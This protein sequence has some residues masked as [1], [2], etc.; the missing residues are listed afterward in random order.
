MMSA[1]VTS[2]RQ[3]N[4]YRAFTTNMLSKSSIFIRRLRRDAYA[5]PKPLSLRSRPEIVAKLAGT[6]RPNTTERTVDFSSDGV[7]IELVQVWFV[8]PYSR[9]SIAMSLFDRLAHFQA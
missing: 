3:C 9:F 1:L 4:R 6:T 5:I 7:D 2:A 8:Q